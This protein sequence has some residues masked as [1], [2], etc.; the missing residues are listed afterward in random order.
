ML[1]LSDREW[2]EFFIGDL[3]DVKRPKSRSEKDYED[4][5][6]PFVASGNV[7]N[8]VIRCCS[9]HEN[10]TVDKGNCISVSPVDGSAFYQ[11][12]DFLGRGGAGSSVLLLYCDKINTY[13][14]LFISRMIRQTCSKYCYGKMGNQ[15]GIKREKILLPKN[16][17]GQPDYDFMEAFIKERE[18]IKRKEYLEY[19][20]RKILEIRGGTTLTTIK[21]ITWCEFF[22]KD[23][24]TKIQRGKRLVRE[25]QTAGTTP[26]ISSSALNNG[27]DN[28]IGN[29]DGVRKFNNCLSLANSG[30]V[31]SCFYE[32]FE[33][34]ASD[35]ITHLKNDNLNEYQYLFIA[36][37]LNR[38]SEKYNFN[39]EINDV[40]ISREKVLLP[41]DENGEPHWS[42]MENY[43]RNCIARKYQ[44]YVSFKSG[45]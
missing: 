26:Y 21:D 38:L 27:V 28:F 20:K 4:G 5:E 9:I 40:R 45:A 14:G 23:I 32:P 22:V 31:G 3:F 44:D 2:K 42:L 10:E 39:R 1:Q 13:S 6:T 36:T 18:E 37:M 29:T 8:G 15:E 34:V 43:M 19:A 41:I 17:D 11:G 16:N 7:N 25:N 33:F 24:F 35:H 30:S 12:A